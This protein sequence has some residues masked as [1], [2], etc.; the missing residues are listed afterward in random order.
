MKTDPFKNHNRKAKLICVWIKFWQ[1][2]GLNFFPLPILSSTRLYFFRKDEEV[3]FI[4]PWAR[5]KKDERWY[6][7]DWCGVFK[8][9][10][11]IDDC[12]KSY[13]NQQRSESQD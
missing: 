5:T 6:G 3:W 11:D 1:K 4:F 2:I 12:R 13:E 10:N 9:L 7:V 8:S